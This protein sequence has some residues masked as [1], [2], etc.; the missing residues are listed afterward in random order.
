V[1][2]APSHPYTQA[3]LD[4]VPRGLKRRARTVLPVEIGESPGG[5]RFRR[6]CVHAIE[7]CGDRVPSLLT[8][9][10]GHL[11]ACHSRQPANESST[12]NSPRR[13]GQ[14]AVVSS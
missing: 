9:G 5:C 3:L 2:S 7:V 11:A 4:A 1:L 14:V 10:P 8:V 13:A 12:S 6:R